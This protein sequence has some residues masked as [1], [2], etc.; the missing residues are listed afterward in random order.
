V[1]ALG[2]IVSFDSVDG[3][4]TEFR[5]DIP[6]DDDSADMASISSRLGNVVVALVDADADNRCVV[7]RTLRD[8]RVDIVQGD[9]MENLRASM[10]LDRRSVGNKTVVFLVRS[11]LYDEAAHLSLSQGTSSVL[12]I[13]GDSSKST[14]RRKTYRSLRQMLPS[15]LMKDLGDLAAEVTPQAHNASAIPHQAPVVQGNK[16]APYHDLRVLIAEDNLVNQVRLPILCISFCGLLTVAF[17]AM[18]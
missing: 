4:W 5:V 14:K 3:K 18:I 12:V 10:L 7:A 16:I 9:S 15:V 1:G 13:F 11:D 6:T 17:F 8:Y 2:G